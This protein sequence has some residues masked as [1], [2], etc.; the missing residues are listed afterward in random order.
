MNFI[1]TT[2]YAYIIEENFKLVTL[3]TND[4]LSVI[5]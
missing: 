1:Y 2:T 3:V 4:F 5:V